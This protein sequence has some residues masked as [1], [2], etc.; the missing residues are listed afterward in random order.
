MLLG[1]D[2]ASANAE[3][4]I[5]IEQRTFET[6]P[7]AVEIL[8]K[9]ER[10]DPAPG[11]YRTFRFHGWEPIAWLNN[12][13]P[14]RCREFV[15]WERDTIQ[16]KYGLL[17][18]VDYT[19]TRGTAELYDYDWFF[20]P[21]VMTITPEVADSLK[22]ISRGQAVAGRQIVCYPR[23]GFDMW[24]T[25]YFLLPMLA[26]GWT[27]ERR[28]YASF[29]PKSKLVYPTEKEFLAFTTE[30]LRD[31]VVNE[32]FQILKNEAAYPRPGSSIKQGSSRRS[33]A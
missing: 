12:S 13:S 3:L 2:L 11:P 30:A 1:F 31:R 32:D 23:R 8:E 27:Y 16:P 5:T 15:I 7:K 9:L 33:K 19:A 24:N 22:R 18:D 21:F 26:G 17:W 25:R 6:K 29:L 4:I 20:G 10:E 14:D 28:G